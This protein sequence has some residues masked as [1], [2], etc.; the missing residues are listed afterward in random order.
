MDW[1]TFDDR[2]FRFK[3]DRKSR[4]CVVTAYQ[5]GPLWNTLGNLTSKSKADY[6]QRHGYGFRAYKQGWDKS[7]PKSWSKLLFIRDTLRSYEWVFWIDA[8]AAITNQTVPLGFFIQKDEEMVIC[9]VQNLATMDE[10]RHLN[11]GVFL[12]K[13][14][15]FA[16]SLLE[17]LWG[18]TDCINHP[19]WEQ[20]AF[21]IIYGAS[22]DVQGHVRVTWGRAFNSVCPWRNQMSSEFKWWPGDFV[23][24]IAAFPLGVRIEMMRR[25]LFMCYGKNG[26]RA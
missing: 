21:E 1:P 2:V 15:K 19:W 3:Q 25:I 4:F 26:V 23:I 20:K 18:Q 5:D 7:R 11:C 16:E 17:A 8:D 22:A 9:K 6:C 12:L 24:H 10:H 14:G 13:A